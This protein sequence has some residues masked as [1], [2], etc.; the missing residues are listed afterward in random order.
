MFPYKF[1]LKMAN[2]NDDFIESDNWKENDLYKV[3]L[4]L[5]Q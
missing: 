2:K 4:H 1:S 5:T 3:S